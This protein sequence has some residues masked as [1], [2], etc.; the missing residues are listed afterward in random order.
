MDDLKF[1]DKTMQQ[2]ISL[3]QT[4]SFSSDIEMQF[5]MQFL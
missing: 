3:M 1:H 4:V 5:G 2:L